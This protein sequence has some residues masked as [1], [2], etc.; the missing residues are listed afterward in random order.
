[1]EKN[2]K[3]RGEAE[4]IIMMKIIGIEKGNRNIKQKKVKLKTK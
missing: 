3:T 4:Q 2:C 1:M